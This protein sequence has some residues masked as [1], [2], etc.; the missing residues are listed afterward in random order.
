MKQFNIM[1]SLAMVEITYSSTN[2]YNLAL[3]KSAVTVHKC[4]HSKHL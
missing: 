3:L 1:V 2:F 4:I